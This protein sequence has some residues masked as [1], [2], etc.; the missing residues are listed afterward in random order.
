MEGARRHSG[1][2]HQGLLGNLVNR[3]AMLD[4]VA[5]GVRYPEGKMLVLALTTPVK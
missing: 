4:A 3:I 1:G 2:R 5:L